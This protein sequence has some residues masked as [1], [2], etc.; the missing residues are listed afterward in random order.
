MASQPPDFLREWREGDRAQKAMAVF[1]R[2]APILLFI[3]FMYFFTTFA[4]V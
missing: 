1:K 4:G 2:A 3:V